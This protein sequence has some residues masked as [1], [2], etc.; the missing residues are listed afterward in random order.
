MMHYLEN[1]VAIC[2][3]GLLC[4]LRQQ[5]KNIQSH[6]WPEQYQ[7]VFQQDATLFVDC[8]G[9]FLTGDM[10]GVLMSADIFSR[11]GTDTVEKWSGCL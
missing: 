3:T 10:D 7:T 6:E 5:R 1:N 9:N 4:P 11:A 2:C 8:H